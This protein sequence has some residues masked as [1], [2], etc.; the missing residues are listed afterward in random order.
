MINAVDTGDAFAALDRI[1]S[2]FHDTCVTHKK[3]T[4]PHSMSIHIIL[5]IV[6]EFVTIEI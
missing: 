2:L 5:H 1:P 6:R 3:Q 4:N